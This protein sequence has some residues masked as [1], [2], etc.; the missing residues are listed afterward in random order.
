MPVARTADWGW[1]PLLAGMA[2]RASL[3]EVAD[4][5]GRLKW[6][7]DLLVQE[8]TG[9]R[10]DHGAPWRK[11]SGVLAEVVP[12]AGLVVIGAGANIDQVRGELPVETA[13][14]L[15]LCGSTRARR[16]DVIVGYLEALADLHQAWSAGG[17]ELEALRAAYRSSC[18]TIGL[19]V[20]VHQ[21]GRRVTHGTATGVDDTG[22]LVVGAG[23]S[24]TAHAAG[25]VMHVRRSAP[26]RG[27]TA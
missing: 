19:D 2:M 4:V 17:A 6:P 1:L 5:T 21:P 8:G 10:S 11:I 12:G 23:A 22:R 24:S 9:G 16:E 26:A 25:D 18:M 3:A 20:D 27:N 15:L 7:N 14:S 13:T